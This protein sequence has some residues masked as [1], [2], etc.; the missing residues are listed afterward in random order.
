MSVL[1]DDA[2]VITVVAEI[3]TARGDDVM[4][5]P[6]HPGIDEVEIDEA[7]PSPHLG[8]DDTAPRRGEINAVAGAAPVQMVFTRLKVAAEEEKVAAGVMIGTGAAEVEEEDTRTN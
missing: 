6:G 7:D 8:G 3:E 2:M 5:P 1:R 4:I